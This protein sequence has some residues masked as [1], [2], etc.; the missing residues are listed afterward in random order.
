[1]ELSMPSGVVLEVEDLSKSYETASG[2]AVRALDRVS[3]RVSAGELV[4][5][6][7]PSGSGKTTLLKLLARVLDPD[8]GLV[9]V[10]G[11]D[12]AGFR[13]V[14]LDRYRL[15]EL[16]LVLQSAQLVGGVNVVANAA[17]RLME[18]RMRWR[19]AQLAVVPLLERLDLGRELERMPSE[20]SVGE[21]QRVAIASALATG[22]GL[23]LA[24]EPT[25]GLDQRRGRV[26]LELL[27]EV[28]R[29]RGAAAL[30]TTHDPLAT[31][32]ADRAWALRDGKL[33]EHGPDLLDPTSAPAGR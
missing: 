19:E 2:E 14:D 18:R 28:C 3:F 25:G 7:G 10:R 30:I 22:P 16:G 26:V 17:L 33:I 20:L 5:V 8:G 12:I 6:Y 32:V 21:R 27:A 9:R 11:R 4:A 29:E 23:V 15:E 13:G 24:D 1:M 31:T